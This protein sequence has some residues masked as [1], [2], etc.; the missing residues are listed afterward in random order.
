MCK[1]CVEHKVNLIF[2]AVSGTLPKEVLQ[3]VAVKMLQLLPKIDL[4]QNSD[5]IVIKDSVLDGRIE[6]VIIQQPDVPK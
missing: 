5:K 6:Q 1:Y 2:K 4:S 3:D